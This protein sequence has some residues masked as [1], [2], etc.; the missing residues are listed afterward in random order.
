VQLGS[1][2]RLRYEL[3]TLGR[4][5]L[6]LDRDD[7]GGLEIDATAWLDRPVYSHLNTFCD[8]E[9]RG[10][11]RLSLG[12]SPCPETPVEVRRFDY[13]FGRPSRFA[14]V[15]ANRRFRVVEA[16]TGEKGPFRTLAEGVLKPEDPLVIT[17][18]DQD[19][20]RV[21][22]TLHDWSAQASTQLS[23]TAGWGVPVNA[24]EFSLNDDDG[25]TSAASIFIT[26]AGTSVG[27]GWDSVGHAAGAYRNRLTVRPVGDSD[28]RR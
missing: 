1:G 3:A 20:P 18:F 19:Q 4:S 15:S 2:G 24:I 23:P 6:T 10:H 9:V 13:P 7:T 27:R 5:S 25:P 28:S 22:V 12:F 14:Y 16:Q 11:S 26:L 21:A 17:V 8:I